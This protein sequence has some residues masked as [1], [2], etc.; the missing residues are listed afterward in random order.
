MG[1]RDHL[2]TQ[3]FQTRKSETWKLGVLAPKLPVS[4]LH[5]QCS[6]LP[7]LLRE[8]HTTQQGLKARLGTQHIPIRG[9]LNKDHQVSLF[10]SSLQP[11]ERLVF[12]AEATVCIRKDKGRDMALLCSFFQ[13]LDQYQRL[14]LF[15]CQGVGTCETTKFKRL[16]PRPTCASFQGDNSFWIHLFLSIGETQAKIITQTFKFLDCAVVLSQ[17]PDYPCGI[18]LGHVVERIQFKR[19][20]H[21]AHGFVVSSYGQ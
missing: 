4:R 10:V 21:L 8:V 17:C 14:S 1:H 2:V 13:L 7:R 5:S 18:I 20:I 3:N 9:C 11:R 12:F 6:A 16:P 15:S 19:V